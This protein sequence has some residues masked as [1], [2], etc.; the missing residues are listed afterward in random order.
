MYV[1]DELTPTVDLKSVSNRIHG[2]NSYFF[3]AVL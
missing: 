1:C 3:I 2:G